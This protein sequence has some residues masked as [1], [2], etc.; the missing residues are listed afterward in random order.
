MLIG[1]PLEAF[2]KFNRNFKKQKNSWVFL[3]LFE[4]FQ[5]IDNYSL[6]LESRTMSFF[7]KGQGNIF[8][9]MAPGQVWDQNN[10]L[11]T[12]HDC[13]RPKKAWNKKEDPLTNR[14]STTVFKKRSLTQGHK[15][16]APSNKLTMQ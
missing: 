12:D 2:T 1:F 4:F 14:Y 3:S 8:N 11:S 16:L 9:I 6:Q 5:N 10:F 13:L 7:K 15:F